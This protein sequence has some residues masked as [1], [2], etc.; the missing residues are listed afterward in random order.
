MKPANQLSASEP[1]LPICHCWPGLYCGCQ[2]IYPDFLHWPAEKKTRTT[3]IPHASSSAINFHAEQNSH[4]SLRRNDGAPLAPANWIKLRP[5]ERNKALPAQHTSC[6]SYVRVRHTC[7]VKVVCYRLCININLP[8]SRCSILYLHCSQRL[9]PRRLK[10]FKPVSNFFSWKRSKLFTPDAAEFRTRLVFPLYL[11]SCE[12]WLIFI[13][14]FSFN[15]TNCFVNV[16][17]CFQLSLSQQCGSLWAMHES[18][19]VCHSLSLKLSA[20]ASSMWVC[21]TE[22]HLK[23]AESR[24]QHIARNH[25]TGIN[26]LCHSFPFYWQLHPVSER[27]CFLSFECAWS[28]F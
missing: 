11:K 9:H 24:M 27:C 13:F 16:A 3:P 1:P 2:P 28:V 22:N 26:R 25:I 6:R 20:V 18:S 10:Q 8:L 15:F 4:C 5:K 14:I 21:E 12:W 7:P 19:S 17:C 23:T